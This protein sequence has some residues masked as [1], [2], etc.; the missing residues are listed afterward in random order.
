MNSSTSPTH[1]QLINL[2]YLLMGMIFSYTGECADGKLF[3]N[4][5]V[6]NRHEHVLSGESPSNRRKG[7]K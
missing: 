4:A 6:K 1:S 5:E 7:L 3:R 2:A